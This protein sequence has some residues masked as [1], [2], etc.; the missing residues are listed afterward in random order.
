M[1]VQV[2]PL[3]K[4]LAPYL[5][6]IA[7]SAIPAFTSKP[8]AAKSDPLVA[9]QIKELQDASIK[10]VKELHTLAEQLQKVIASADEAASAAERKIAKYKTILVASLALSAVALVTALIAIAR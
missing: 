5:T 7:T 4:T 3:I 9:Q 2:L 1:A 8:E 10:S 6:Q